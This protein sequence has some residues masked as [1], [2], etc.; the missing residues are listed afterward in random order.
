MECEKAP[1][2]V[3]SGHIG[4]RARWPIPAG[5]DV[6]ASLATMTENGRPDG[7]PGLGA[8]PLRAG[9]QPAGPPAGRGGPPEGRSIEVVIFD[10]DGVLVDSEIWWDDVRRDFAR[11]HGRPWTLGDRHA[12]MGQNSRQW[13]ATMQQRL[14]L[15]LSTLDIEAAVVDAMVERYRRE[16]PPHIDGAAD[17][18]RRIAVSRRIAVASSAHRAVIE[19]ALEGLGIGGLLDVVVS[20]DEVT[21]GKPAPDVYV[22]TARRLGVAP[23]RCLVVEDSINGIRAAKAAGMVAV[24]VPNESVPPADGAAALADAVVARLEDVETL[25]AGGP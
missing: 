11:A 25:L 1:K 23:G 8:G 4:G 20:S 16:G 2:D 24:L 7:G 6:C 15:E 13:A 3:A 18:L 9:K 12:V 22:E 21:H 19:S 14:N 17:A 5:R 10:L